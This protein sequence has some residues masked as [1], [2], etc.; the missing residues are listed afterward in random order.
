[1][2][3]AAWTP[4]FP[5]VGVSIQLRAG[6]ACSALREYAGDAA[7]LILGNGPAADSPEPTL[8]LVVDTALGVRH[9][10][11]LL[12]PSSSPQGWLASPRLDQAE[13]P[14]S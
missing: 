8:D 2:S 14:V 5:D 10:P 11:T 13:R 3:L 1:L 12:I 9:A 7:L 4:R 6:D